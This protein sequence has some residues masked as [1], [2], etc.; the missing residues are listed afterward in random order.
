LFG[1]HLRTARGA[2]LFLLAFGSAAIWAAG[3]GNYAV[4][5][6]GLLTASALSLEKER[7][8]PFFAAVLI[9]GLFKIYYLWFLLFPL[10]IDFRR[11]LPGT[12]G[13]V[14]AAAVVYGG[15]WWLEP[16]LFMSFVRSSAEVLADVRDYGEGFFGIAMTAIDELAARTSMKLP[17][18]TAYAFYALSVAFI[19][20]IVLPLGRMYRRE[21]DASRRKVLLGLLWIAVL[22]SLPRFKIY[23]AF[24][25]IIPLLVILERHFFCRRLEINAGWLLLA[26][27]AFPSTFPYNRHILPLIGQHWTALVVTG[28]WLLACDAIL[29]TG[30]RQPALNPAEGKV[31]RGPVEPGPQSGNGLYDLVPAQTTIASRT[32]GGA[33]RGTR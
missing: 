23:D 26:V 33:F 12:L 3:S 30:A 11:Y 29:R 28:C 1:L 5:I 19:A 15:A 9:A 16:G 7:P 32:G 8:V 21:T 25:V 31:Q 6:Y 4:L 10:A 20:A 14:I 22:L 24:A 13:T 2:A 17:R 27:I 18:A